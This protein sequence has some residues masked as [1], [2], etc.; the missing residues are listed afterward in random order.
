M[1]KIRHMINK[2][3][4]STQYK[5]IVISV[6]VY[7]GIVCD[8]L[9]LTDATK[10]T[11]LCPVHNRENWQSR[12]HYTPTPDTKAELPIRLETHSHNSSCV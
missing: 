2:E 3:T 6:I 5:T 10:T 7:V 4:A 9:T 1:E 8:C 12:P 11:I